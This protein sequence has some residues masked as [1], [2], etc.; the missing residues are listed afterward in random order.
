M[1]YLFTDGSIF[2]SEQRVCRFP[3]S[4]RNPPRVRR[5]QYSR[6][7]V[8]RRFAVFDAFRRKRRKCR[9]QGRLTR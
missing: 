3:T 7:G 8:S 2:T 6:L 4:Y 5:V 9:L 1:G